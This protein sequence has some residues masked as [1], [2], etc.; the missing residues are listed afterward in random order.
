MEFQS[1]KTEKFIVKKKTE[2]NML[3]ILI[4]FMQILNQKM[5][6]ESK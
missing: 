1:S 4:G 3:I 6:T 2:M 5:E